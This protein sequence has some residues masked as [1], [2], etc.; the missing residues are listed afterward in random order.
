MMQEI[1]FF[2]DDFILGVIARWGNAN[3]SPDTY[4]INTHMYA[5]AEELDISLLPGTNDARHAFATVKFPNP[6]MPEAAFSKG[7]SSG[8]PAFEF[9][10]LSPPGSAD[11]FIFKGLEKIISA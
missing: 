5:I 2:C 8:R 1:T 10:R 11:C 4:I 7:S 6:T 3:K 9:C